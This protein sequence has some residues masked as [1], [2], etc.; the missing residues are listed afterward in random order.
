MKTSSI[1][2]LA[3]T[4][5]L[6]LPV[7]F[8]SVHAESQTN[9]DNQTR[10]DND[11]SNYMKNLNGTNVGQEVSDFVHNATAKFKQQRAENIQAIKDCH[12]KIRSATGENR[13]QI[14]D[15][16]HTT[17]ATIREK[18]K[19]LRTQFQ[20]LFKEFREHLLALK[21]DAEGSKKLSDTDRDNAIKGINDDAVKHGMKSLNMT[22][23][24]EMK[25]HGKMGTG[26]GMHNS[27]DQS[28]MRGKH[29]G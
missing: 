14:I 28:D 24:K 17:M 18:Y 19:D 29:Q 22:H 4:L 10:S 27:T 25:D 2:L 23:L 8:S 11:K 1:L 9:G 13:T 26:R 3:I 16:C 20:G 12:E 7:G 6:V 21:H 5:S 15:E